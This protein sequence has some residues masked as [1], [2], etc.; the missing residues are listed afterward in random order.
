VAG[1]SDASGSSGGSGGLAKGLPPSA[2]EEPVRPLRVEPD[3]V[4]RVLRPLRVE[5][6]RPEPV[7]AEAGWERAVCGAF[8][9]AGGATPVFP[10]PP[11]TGAI[12]QASQ[13][14]S[15]IVPEHPGCAQVAI[16][17]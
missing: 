17:G 11:P 4:E 6:V 16:G 13:Y 14:P 2:R 10:V 12:P 9:V 15:S 5:G 8:E 1:T 7:R 3:R